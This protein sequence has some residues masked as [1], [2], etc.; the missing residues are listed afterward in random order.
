MTLTRFLT[1]YIY[2][3]LSLWLTRR[4]FAKGL[5]VLAG[6]RT[7]VGAFVFLLM[8]PAILTMAISGLWHG[9]GY[10]FLIW[11]LL[12]G[13]YLTV[14]HAWRLFVVRLWP[15]R[16]SYDRFMAPFGLG[17]TLLAVVASMVFFRS[18]TMAVASDI[19][20][21][22]VGFNGV[23]LPELLYGLVEK[24]AWLR[25]LGITTEI[26]Q[27]LSFTR[28]AFW[29]SI[30]AFIALTCPNTLE[31]LATYEPALGIKPRPAPSSKMAL[32]WRPTVAWAMVVAVVAVWGI[33]RLSS[34]SEFLY[35]QF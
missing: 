23:A 7:T 27:S 19:L 18:P 15:D 34:P 35:W 16:V 24:S 20:R 17:L 1:A 12:H 3:P 13:V 9:A 32:Q 10:L 26:W 29:L 8:F 21:G 30:S 25:N 22:L 2:N 5:P 14:N 31:I 4:R 6:S 11:G 28:L 33:S